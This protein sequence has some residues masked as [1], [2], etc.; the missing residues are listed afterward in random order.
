MVVMVVM[1]VMHG[2]I[3]AICSGITTENPEDFVS[4]NRVRLQ[5]WISRF[6]VLGMLL[7][8]S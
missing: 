6:C 5:S 2:F 1:V 3:L 4:I 8:I 7:I